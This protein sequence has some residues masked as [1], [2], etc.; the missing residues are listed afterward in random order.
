VSELRIAAVTI[1]SV[2]GLEKLELEEPGQIVEITGANGVGKSSILAAIQSALAGGNL[3]NI[4]KA[5]LSEED[6]PPEVELVLRGAGVEE[7]RIRQ[8]PGRLT[9]QERDGDSAAFRPVKQ[10][11]QRIRQLYDQTG[12][13][14]VA[15]LTA[16]PADQALMLLEALP[17]GHYTRAELMAA[18]GLPTVPGSVPIPEGLHWTEEIGMVR[19]AVYDYRTGVNVSARDA[20]AAAQD[21]LRNLP[22]TAGDT[23][24]DEI[25][26]LQQQHDK[27]AAD[28]ATARER[29]QGDMGRDLQDA[30]H[31]HGKA[32]DAAESLAAREKAQLEAG[33]EAEAAQIRA[34]AEKRVARL[35]AEVDVQVDAIRTRRED[36]LQ[37]ALEQKARASE[38]AHRKAD[39]AHAQ[40]AEEVRKLHEVTML[41]AAT[42]ATAEQAIKDGAMLDMARQREAAALQLEG[43]SKRLTSALDALDRYRLALTS[44]LPIPG[45]EIKGKEIS[46]NGVPFEQLNT[47]QRV[48]IAVRVAL[49]RNKGARLRVLFID[50]SEA[51]DEQNY[52]VLVAAIRAEGAS[53]FIARRG[54]GELELRKVA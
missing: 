4:A 23:H 9:M 1:S 40:L 22:A 54:D 20:K 43:E 25:L 16:K 11:A 8:V 21:M 34:E 13:N 45:L 28:I 31:Q 17:A 53:A 12:S 2:K 37:D 48:S 7:Y 19:A 3:A 10:P 46:V 36:Q 39:E 51:L 27:L 6:E 52:A 5:G 44:E 38:D 33:F 35:R 15:F 47:A 30:E 50:N 41:L 32:H 14:P 42:R 26:R 49:L 24:A 18:M 29:I